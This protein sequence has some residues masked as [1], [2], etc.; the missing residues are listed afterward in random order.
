MHLNDIIMSCNASTKKKKVDW[1]I[2]FLH[3]LTITH[4]IAFK[5]FVHDYVFLSL[6]FSICIGIQ[7]QRKVFIIRGYIFN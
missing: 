2:C 7:P 4:R 6:F 3:F 5:D 1:K